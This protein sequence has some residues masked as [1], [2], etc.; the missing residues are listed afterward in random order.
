M[1]STNTTR[2]SHAGLLAT[3]SAAVSRSNNLRGL[4]RR[5][6]QNAAGDLPASVRLLFVEDLVDQRLLRC[7]SEEAWQFGRRP[8]KDRAIRQRLPLILTIQI[9]AQQRQLALYRADPAVGPLSGAHG[10]R[11]GCAAP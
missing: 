8:Q 6:R 9:R 1:S 3:V 2:P 10:T 5:R 11:S 7:L 4:H